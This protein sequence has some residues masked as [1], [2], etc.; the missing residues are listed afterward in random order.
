M[1]WHIAIASDG[2]AKSGGAP[3][4]IVIRFAYIMLEYNKIVTEPITPT[5]KTKKQ[6]KFTLETAHTC[7]LRHRR[8]TGL[9]HFLY[10]SCWF[11]RDGS[12][13]G[14]PVV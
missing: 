8:L 2:V 11:D 14:G 9:A 5:T 4:I 7:Q 1:H 13:V 12:L 6:I 3:T 10:I